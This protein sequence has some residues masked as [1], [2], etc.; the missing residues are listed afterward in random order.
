MKT[1]TNCSYVFKEDNVKICTFLEK[2]G[3]IPYSQ[4]EI[5]KVYT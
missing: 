1:S 3:Y 4:K 5:P 2:K